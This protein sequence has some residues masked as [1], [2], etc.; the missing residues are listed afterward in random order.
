[1]EKLLTIAIPTYNRKNFLKKALDSILC[2]M[3][4]RVEILVSDNVSDDGT[5]EMMKKEYPQIRYSR[6]SENVG[7][8]K[9]F[10]ICCNLARGKFFILLGSD[11]IVIEGVVA[12]ILDF[13]EHNPECSAVFMNH[14]FYQGEYTDLNNCYKKWREKF[15]SFVTNDK[16]KFIEYVGK[17]ISFMSCSIL[18]KEK[19]LTIKDP[20]EFIGTYFI[21]TNLL[22]EMT[23]SSTDVLGIIGDYCIADNVT[24][25]GAT[26]DKDLSVV[27]EI[28]GKGLEYTFCN[29]AVA[30]GYDKKQMTENFLKY[31]R[32]NW[33]AVI[34]R[35][36][37]YDNP[38]W[39][40]KFKEYGYPIIKKYPSLWFKIMPY[41]FVPRCIARLYHF[42][43]R[44]FIKGKKQ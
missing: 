14:A 29:H 13:L 16:K 24:P 30:C 27:F 12:K 40:K 3:D 4:D 7:V 41:Y 22:L 34:I 21:H 38:N 15:E 8:D 20:T 25:G 23:K 17:Q 35:L 19:F 32:D 18:S 26:I 43:F 36:K 31:P 10:L 1:M 39:K 9:N 28:F 42:R 6:N 33:A 37:A 44:P 2:Q 11:D 5:E